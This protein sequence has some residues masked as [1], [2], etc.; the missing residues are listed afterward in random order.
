MTEGSQPDRP[1]QP[2]LRPLRSAIRALRLRGQQLRLGRKMT[3]GRNVSIG[4]AARLMPPDHIHLSENISI[5]AEFHLETNL[6]VGPDVLISSRVAFVGRDHRFDDP[7]KS[8]FWT[9]RAPG[10]LVVLEGNN[11]IGF[12]AI[13]IAPARIGRGCIVGSGSVVVGNLPADTVCAGVPARPI[14]GRYEAHA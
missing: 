2:V 4:R 14:R 5:G 13:I 12:G 11:L 3:T 1:I 7:S 8:V 10:G 9:G 6:E